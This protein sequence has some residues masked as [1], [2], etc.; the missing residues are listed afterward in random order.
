MK[1]HMIKHGVG[2]SPIECC[3]VLKWLSGL[4]LESCPKS[5]KLRR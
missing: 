4:I 2:V 3:V 5:C 1:G